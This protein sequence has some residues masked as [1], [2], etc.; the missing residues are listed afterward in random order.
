M[1][2]L[3]PLIGGH[4][5]S[6]NADLEDL[7]RFLGY[8]PNALLTMARVEG[9]LP[10]VL[11]LVKVTI[12]NEAV[13]SSD[14][15]FLVAAE[16]SRSVGCFYSATHAVHAAEHQGVPLEKLA[17]LDRCETS[18]HYTEAE[19]AALQL[20]RLSARAPVG[21]LHPAW[22]RARKSY[23]EDALL[24]LCSAIAAFG[25]FNRWNS[26]IGSELEPEPASVL[27]SVAWLTQI[28]PAEGSR[29][30]DG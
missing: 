2:Q 23:S 21:D 14:L 17:D 28:R 27:D 3:Y 9:L 5:G 4:S 12:R 19:R 24:A 25:W 22:E 13:I 30:H 18:P 1:P 11:A 7:V 29:S 6:E 8:R 20:A 16:A 10:A 26:M 15:R